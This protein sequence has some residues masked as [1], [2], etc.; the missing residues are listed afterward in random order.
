MINTHTKSAD[1]EV[2]FSILLANLYVEKWL[3]ILIA[4]VIILTSIFYAN[5]LPKR[6]TIATHITD[7]YENNDIINFKNIEASLNQ[8]IEIND[9]NEINI[10]D[11]NEIVLKERVNNN[12]A[13]TSML[14]EALYRLRSKNYHSNLFDKFNFSNKLNLGMTKESFLGKINFK[15]VRNKNTDSEEDRTL[16]VPYG[17]FAN[18][19]NKNEIDIYIEFIELLMSDVKLTTSQNIIGNLS[20]KVKIKQE[21]LIQELA[22]Y[23][24]FYNAKVL[25]KQNKNK[26]NQ[27][28]ELFNINQEIEFLKSQIINTKENS[29]IELQAQKDI[30]KAMGMKDNTSQFLAYPSINLG[31]IK[32]YP[33]W[34]LFGEKAINEE[35]KSLR[36]YDYLE[37]SELLELKFSRE[38]ILENAKYPNIII[39]DAKFKYDRELSN[40]SVTIDNLKKNIIWL[41]NLTLDPFRIE[42]P[43]KASL[44]PS[45]SNLI[46]FLGIFSGLFIS[47]LFAIIRS[48]FR[49]HKNI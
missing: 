3:I 27:E 28:I 13:G 12:E 42:L 38:K 33:S 45:K 41:E 10:I 11:V 9:I 20:T 5:S 22:L 25:M 36:K 1:N 6:Y 39:I 43:P 15:I 24:E 17:L 46:I 21:K 18:K 35:L 32:D 7:S 23:K 44:L 40:L 14:P 30:A 37:S 4:S 16:A 2:P 34:L 26:N 49:T 8:K 31:N 48:Q 47:L 19:V 29:I